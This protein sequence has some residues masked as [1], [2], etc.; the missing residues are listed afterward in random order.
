MMLR[1]VRFFDEML[2]GLGLDLFD[3]QMYQRYEELFRVSAREII[4]N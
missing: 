2:K 3:E 1:K 4:K